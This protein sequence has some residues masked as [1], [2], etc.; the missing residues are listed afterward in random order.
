LFSG[1]NRESIASKAVVNLGQDMRNIQI[2]LGVPA[3]QCGIRRA[4]YADEFSAN[5]EITGFQE[6]F[7]QIADQPEINE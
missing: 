5:S 6:D 1:E 7:V 2:P 3:L 4:S